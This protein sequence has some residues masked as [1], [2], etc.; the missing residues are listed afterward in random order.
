MSDVTIQERTGQERTEIQERAAAQRQIET[1]ALH[2][3]ELLQYLGNQVVGQ[4]LLKR[5]LVIALITGGHVLLEGVPGLGKT[6]SIKAL[7]S[8]VHG[9][10]RR[11]QFTPDLLPGDVVGTEVFRP[12]DGTFEVRPGPV[13]ANFVLADEI[14]RAPAKVQSALLET[15]QEHQVTIGSQTFQLPK[16][17]LVMA[18]QNPIEQEGTYPLPEAQVDRFM[19]KV[20]LTYPK[21]DEERE[22]LDLVVGNNSSPGKT[23]QPILT[24]EQVM[25]MQQAVC[26]VYVDSRVK[27]YILDLVWA[28]REPER[29]GLKLSPLIQL[30]ASPRSTISLF[31]AARAEAYLNSETFVVPQHVKDVAYDVFRHRVVPSYEAE[32]EGRDA[33]SIISEILE[34]VQVP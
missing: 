24:L 14:N 25:E 22:M 12:Q 3:K 13:F 5:R 15:M 6:L 17:F 26:E 4:E 31:L 21:P 30:G 20:K 10:F 28:S 7:A 9:T 1:T 29:F 32:V 27:K 16:P 18:T 19:M 34:S 33:D 8:A 23:Y 11:V 2:A